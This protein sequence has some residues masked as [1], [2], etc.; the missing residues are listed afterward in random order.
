M[1][2][3][4]SHPNMITADCWGGGSGPGADGLL[5]SRVMSSATAQGLRQVKIREHQPS[6]AIRSASTRWGNACAYVFHPAITSTGLPCAS[7]RPFL[8]NEQALTWIRLA[9]KRS[10]DSHGSGS[11]IYLT[12]RNRE[13]EPPVFE[14]RETVATVLDR[15]RGVGP[16]FDFLRVALAMIIFTG[17]VSWLVGRVSTGAMPINGLN[18][19]DAMNALR[20]SGWEGWRRPIQISWVPAFFALSGFLVSGSALRTKA[21]QTF[22]AFRALRIWPALLV[23]LTLSAIILGTFF[24]NLTPQSY[25]TN[26]LLYRYFG[27]LIGWVDFQLPGVF[28]RNPVPSVVNANLWTLPAEFDCYL[29][30]ALLM[31]TRLFYR[32][33]LLT[34]IFIVMTL[35]FVV[36]NGLTDFAVTQTTL[37]AHTVTYYFFVGVMFY[38]WREYIPMRW[39]I[40][41]VSLALTY[42]IQ[43]YHHALYIA[44]IFLTYCT[45]FVGM[46]KIPKIPLINSGDYSYGIYLYGFPITQAVIALFP[47][48]THTRWQAR[49]AAGA[50]TVCFAVF[51]WHVIEKKALNLKRHLPLRWFPLPER[52][53]R[54]TPAERLVSRV[55][56]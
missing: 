44:P 8:H 10:F 25:F 47:M 55:V 56:S 27:N 39:S 6:L 45:I 52:A 5:P 49:A 48:L 13:W 42:F 41:I 22:L 17:H 7:H 54:Q 20:A 53:I 19:V 24:T 50:A 26:P 3:F 11:N 2:G 51:S 30:T 37:P 33:N 29:V 36:L 4:T 12:R 40:F 9:Y 31:L 34:V 23:E 38:H 21:V 16:G 46:V 32:R 28:V 14:R 43:R 15:Y 35:V 18:S 1:Y